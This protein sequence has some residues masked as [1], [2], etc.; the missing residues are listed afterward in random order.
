MILSR[1]ILNTLQVSH[2][3]WSRAQYTLLGVPFPPEKGWLKRMEGKLIS[4][5][6]YQQLLKISLK[7]KRI[8]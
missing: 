3:C 5:T 7:G 2:K 6:T 1:R 8:P 4:D